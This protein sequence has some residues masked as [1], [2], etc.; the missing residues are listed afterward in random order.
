L[1]CITGGREVP[2]NLLRPAAAVANPLTLRGPSW[3]ETGTG[4]PPRDT[5]LPTEHDSGFAVHTTRR[6][7]HPQSRRN[8]DLLGPPGPQMTATPVAPV[9]PVA[10]RCAPSSHLNR[11]ASQLTDAPLSRAADGVALAERSVRCGHRCGTCRQP[12]PAVIP[13]RPSARPRFELVVAAT[14][15]RRRAGSEALD[16]H[17]K[18]RDDARR[19]PSRPGS[20][21]AASRCYL[22]RARF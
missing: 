5:S 7:S 3:A 16:R 14:R 1:N 22:P 13:R 9:A 19:S 15:L 20:C 18:R 11:R 8:L 12:T 17:G 21:G 2:R 10:L 6:T 4:G